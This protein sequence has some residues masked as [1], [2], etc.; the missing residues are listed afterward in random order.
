MAFIIWVGYVISSLS[1]IS[2][3][4]SALTSGSMMKISHSDLLYK[5]NEAFSDSSTLS[6]IGLVKFA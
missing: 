1:D 2:V 5:V 3:S 4:F 6:K